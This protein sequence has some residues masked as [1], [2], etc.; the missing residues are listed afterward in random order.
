MY[1]RDK[2]L[3]CTWYINITMY[4]G[5]T[6]QRQAICRGSRLWSDNHHRI[7]VVSDLNHHL[8]KPIGRLF[9]FDSSTSSTQMLRVPGSE[10]QFFR[11]KV[12]QVLNVLAVL[13]P[14]VLRDTASTRSIW[15]FRT[16]NTTIFAVF[17]V[18]Y[19]RILLYLKYFWVRYCGILSVLEVFKDPVLLILWV[20]AIS[21]PLVLLI[22]SILGV[23]QDF[24]L[25]GA[26]ILAV[27]KG[28]ILRGIAGYSINLIIL[29]ECRSISGFNALDTRSTPSILDFCSAGNACTG[30]YVV[31][32]QYS[33]YLEPSVLLI[34]QVLRVFRPPVR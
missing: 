13:G 18:R 17:G 5:H 23:F 31:Y 1:R 6:C 14:C 3:V 2:W 12:P 30:A 25:R 16:A 26:V 9:L 28:S 34:L 24:I 22:V 29:L 11:A 19:S 32:A 33:Q 7:G 4:T 21:R 27:F 10:V 20:P 15:T 8:Q